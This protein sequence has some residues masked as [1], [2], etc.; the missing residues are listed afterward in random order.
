[1]DDLRLEIPERQMLATLLGV[2]KSGGNPL[3]SISWLGLV[4]WWRSDQLA[5]SRLDSGPKLVNLT[6]LEQKA[7]PRREQAAASEPLRR[8]LSEVPAQFMEVASSLVHFV[9]PSCMQ[10]LEWVPRPLVQ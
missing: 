5:R 3:L 7:A 10:Q 9:K 4:V 2:E 6:R 1:M 8:S